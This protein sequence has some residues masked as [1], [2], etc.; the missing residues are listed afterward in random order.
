MSSNK[1]FQE[2]EIV[3]VTLVVIFLS[4]V[5]VYVAYFHLVGNEQVISS[6]NQVSVEETNDIILENEVDEDVNWSGVVALVNPFSSVSE[7][8]MVVSTN[9]VQDP[10]IPID[11]TS[12]ATYE[13]TLPDD[14]D[15]AIVTDETTG[16]FDVET[17]DTNPLV[18]PDPV[19]S[20]STD[21]SDTT[22][23]AQDLL[24]EILAGL[25]TDISVE[26][27]PVTNTE[28]VDPNPFAWQTE[29]PTPENTT[30]SW[31]QT[32]GTENPVTSS[33]LSDSTPNNLF[34]T[35]ISLGGTEQYLWE[36][37]STSVLGLDYQY[38]LT[39]WEVFYAYL[40]KGDYDYAS[41][42]RNLGWNIVELV[43]EIDIVKNDLFGEKITFV[44]IPGVTYTT[45]PV[46]QRV[47]VYMI[48]RV[49]DDRRLVQVDYASYHRLKTIMR[50]RFAS[51]YESS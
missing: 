12:V 33:P 2:A 46:E 41:V 35:M 14:S 31:D 34:P 9:D 25:W 29:P 44:N 47:V 1:N 43:T 6:N 39:D 3:R 50:D 15:P 49:D 30:P 22:E 40:W 16:E 13:I 27:E 17:E 48:V 7:D 24:A 18:E 45:L 20:T 28:D 32:L 10:I 26:D 8:E 21:D 38:A 36:L 11:E 5:I 4:L 51:H 19:E 37:Q 42:A 23:E